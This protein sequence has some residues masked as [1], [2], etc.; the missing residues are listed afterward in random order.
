MN[1]SAALHSLPFLDATCAIGHNPA[2]LIPAG[3]DVSATALLK[4]MDQLGIAEACPYSAVAAHYAIMEGNR[5]LVREIGGRR[6]LHPVWIA[7][8]HHTGEVPPP[9]ELLREMTAGGVRA[10]KMI[11]H[12]DNGYLDG[13]DAFLCRELFDALAERRIPLMLDFYSFGQDDAAAVR[14]TLQTWPE[15]PVVLTFPKLGKEE[16]LLY[17]LW[18]RFRNLHVTLGGYQVLGGIEKAVA[19]FGAGAFVFGSQYPHFT[20]LQSMLQLIYSE[21]STADKRRIAG[22]TMRALLAQAGS[23]RMRKKAEGRR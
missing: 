22:D 21:I 10:V 4:K 12:S 1:D 23:N 17:A 11:F 6:R 7:A 9:R 16:R 14:E 18:E 3:S 8:P 2:P 5:Q 13:L 20:P 19:R 15:L